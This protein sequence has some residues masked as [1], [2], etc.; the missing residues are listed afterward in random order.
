M[1]HCRVVPHDDI[2]IVFPHDSFDVFFLRCVGKKAVDEFCRPF[3]RHAVNVVAVGRA[4]E[5][6][7]ASLVVSRDELVPGEFVVARINIVIELW[8]SQFA[9][10]P[11]GVIRDE[12]VDFVLGLFWEVVIGCT[13]VEI[14][15]EMVSMVP[16]SR[17]HEA[18]HIGLS[19]CPSW[20]DLSSSEN[21]VA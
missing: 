16:R 4:E 12:A 1:Q 18:I 10:M 11:H 20:R 21:G 8:G 17:G 5:E 9:V 15:S 7:A 19:A 3:V 2:V 6:L 13:S 14:L